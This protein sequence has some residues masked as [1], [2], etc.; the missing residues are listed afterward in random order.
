MGRKTRKQILYDGCFGHI[1]SRA[2]E[3]KR[4]FRDGPDFEFFKGFMRENKEKY[5]YRVH[6]YCLMH[7]HFHLLVGMESVEKFS[8]GMRELKRLYANRVHKEHKGYGPVW[9]GRYG[10]QLIEDE[11]Y[12]S[13]CGLYIEMNPVK[14]GMVGKAEEWPHS[15]NSCLENSG[16]VL[17]RLRS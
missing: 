11:R 5:D 6:H 12:L 10:S 1:Y 16:W 9:W 13:A 3:H 15:S 17:C 4:I 2:L 7:T 8:R 14:A